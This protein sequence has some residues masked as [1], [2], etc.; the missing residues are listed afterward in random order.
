M[1]Q[2]SPKNNA[3]PENPSLETILKHVEGN[4]DFQTELN[5][6]FSSSYQKALFIMSDLVWKKYRNQSLT[7]VRAHMNDAAFHLYVAYQAIG[8]AQSGGW[9][10][11][12]FG[13]TPQ[14]IPFIPD[15]FEDLGWGTA[16]EAFNRTVD[17]F[18]EGTIFNLNDKDYIDILNFIENPRRKIEH[19]KL[20][21]YSKTEREQYCHNYEQCIVRLEEIT[22]A[23]W[24]DNKEWSIITHYYNDN[25]QKRIW[26]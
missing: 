1:K 20:L 9:A 19:P 5:N 4:N 13:N 16:V 3:L 10:V 6:H 26:E 18:P 8:C 12:V 7:E 23:L 14:L 17:A 25:L 21:Q 22:D 2:N 11:G 24:V 15:A